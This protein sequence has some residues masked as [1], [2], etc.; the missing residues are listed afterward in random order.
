MNKRSL[1]NIALVICIALSIVSIAAFI[2]NFHTLPLSKKTGDWSNFGSY[3]SGTIGPLMALISIL[4]V[5][6]SLEITNRN[7]DSV[8]DFNK[9]DKI[10]SQIKDLSDTIKVSLEENFIFKT[11]SIVSTPYSLTI[12][13][14]ISNL[15]PIRDQLSLEEVAVSAVRDGFN[16]FSSEIKL[17][18]KVISL[19]NQLSTSD[20][21]VYKGLIEVRLTN[22]MRAVLYCFACKDQPTDAAY[23][24]EQWPSFLGHFFAES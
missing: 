21:E 6:R 23:I 11:E 8:M 9:T 22:E 10:Q 16:I 12:C 14:R 13:N 1:L 20:K 4:F 2:I 18:L 3:I 7:H 5:L 15:M 19:L 17:I 24:K